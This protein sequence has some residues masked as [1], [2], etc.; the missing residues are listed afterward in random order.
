MNLREPQQWSRPYGG[1][2]PQRARHMM[3]RAATDQEHAMMARKDLA[4]FNPDARLN[5]HKH[6]S[7]RKRLG[8]VA[9]A[10][11]LAASASI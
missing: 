1:D 10:T 8:W 7:P 11:T 5:P 3:A 9:S 2:E 4:N 6:L